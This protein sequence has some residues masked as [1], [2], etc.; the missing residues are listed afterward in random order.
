MRKNKDQCNIK[1]IS[2]S[3]KNFYCSYSK[4]NKGKVCLH[5][6]VIELRI[7]LLKPIYV[8]LYNYFD[9]ITNPET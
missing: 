2:V 4:I 9:L 7:E 1:N 8:P 6:A 3:I 5:M